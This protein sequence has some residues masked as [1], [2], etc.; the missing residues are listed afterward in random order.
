MLTEAPGRPILS[1]GSVQTKLLKLSIIINVR[2]FS[3]LMLVNWSLMFIPLSVSLVMM[4]LRRLRALGLAS[5]SAKTAKSCSEFY[6]NLLSY[7]SSTSYRILMKSL[8]FWAAIMFLMRAYS[9]L[10]SILSTVYCHSST[11][12]HPSLM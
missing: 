3:S 7:Y 10:S 5:V 4:P 6:L 12:L 11:F 9:R 2:V 1:L 8:D